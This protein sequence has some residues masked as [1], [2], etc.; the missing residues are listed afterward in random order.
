MNNFLWN[1]NQNSCIFIQ[2]NAFDNVVCKMAAI[3][4]RSEYVK[5]RGF[6]SN[7]RSLSVSSDSFFVD[8]GVCVDFQFE[9]WVW[10]IK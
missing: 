10:I 5:E 2:E 1:R 3:L 4:S 8:V 7:V 6:S 9:F